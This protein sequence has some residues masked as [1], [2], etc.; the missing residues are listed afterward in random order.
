MCEGGDG[1]GGGTVC[2]CA[3]FTVSAKKK[4]SPSLLV[5]SLWFNGQHQVPWVSKREITREGP[6]RRLA[7]I[8]QALLLYVIWLC[9]LLG[10]NPCFFGLCKWVPTCTFIHSFIHPSI[11]YLYGRH[12]GT[13]SWNSMMNKLDPSSW[14]QSSDKQ[15]AISWCDGKD[16]DVRRFGNVCSWPWIGPESWL[17]RPL[18]ILPDHIFWSTALLICRPESMFPTLPMNPNKIFNSRLCLAILL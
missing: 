14:A 9:A 2:V 8:L 5:E 15:E 6:C 4:G 10:S 3:R 1:G 12:W 16:H 13:Q 18:V 11:Q 17:L 7:H